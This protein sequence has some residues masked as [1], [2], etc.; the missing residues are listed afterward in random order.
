MKVGTGQPGGLNAS[1]CSSAPVTGWFA[2]EIQMARHCPI[3]NRTRAA[4]EKIKIAMDSTREGYRS[5]MSVGNGT[6]VPKIRSVRGSR[7]DG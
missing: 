1:G 4:A 3:P 6:T 5:P 7:N 2:V